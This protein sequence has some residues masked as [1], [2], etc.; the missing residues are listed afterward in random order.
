MFSVSIHGQGWVQGTSVS[1]TCKYEHLLQQRLF[2][3]RRGIA[4]AVLLRCFILNVPETAALITVFAG[5]PKLYFAAPSSQTPPASSIRHRDQPRQG[6][7]QEELTHC[8]N[9]GAARM[10]WYYVALVGE[11]RRSS[12]LQYAFKAANET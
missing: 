2:K 5:A 10:Y 9:F 11:A 1:A 6:S 4:T 12:N 7:I 3:K 8:F